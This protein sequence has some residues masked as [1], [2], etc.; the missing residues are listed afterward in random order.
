MTLQWNWKTV[1][2]RVAAVSTCADW[3]RARM[4][5]SEFLNRCFLCWIHE[6]LST[7]LTCWLY[8]ETNGHG[9]QFS[10]D[11]VV[12]TCWCHTERQRKCSACSTPGFLRKPNG[13][14]TQW[15]WQRVIRRA[16]KMSVVN[17]IHAEFFVYVWC[18]FAPVNAWRNETVWPW[19]TG[20]LEDV[21]GS[22][23]IGGQRNA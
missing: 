12:I 4:D 11:V 7:I 16:L 20:F 10:G 9:T 22:F 23:H 14:W 3:H 2:F 13:V 19:R 8:C 21:S 17:M 15:T 5:I 1:A 6:T 18:F